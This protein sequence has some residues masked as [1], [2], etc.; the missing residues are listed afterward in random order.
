MSAIFYFLSIKCNKPRPLFCYPPDKAVRWSCYVSLS[1]L[2]IIASCIITLFRVGV[3]T[4][5]SGLGYSEF[6][7]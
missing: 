7:I 5:A 2:A 3:A 1:F 4:Q 6:E